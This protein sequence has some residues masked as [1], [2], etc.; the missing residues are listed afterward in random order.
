MGRGRGST[1]ET[2]GVASRRAVTRSPESNLGAPI[3]GAFHHQTTAETAARLRAGGWDPSSSTGYF[4]A[5]LY[6]S[7]EQTEAG[8]YGGEDL[9]FEAELKRPFDASDDEGLELLEEI[10]QLVI[11]KIG[12][13]DGS[14]EWLR[15]KS[16]GITEEMRSRGYDGVLTSEDD[17]VVFDRDSAHVSGS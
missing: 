7:R 5:G 14:G 13:P 6:L 1:W 15:A 12:P 3:A 4:G 17:I 9:V 16:A 11:E 8:T 2:Q 10:G